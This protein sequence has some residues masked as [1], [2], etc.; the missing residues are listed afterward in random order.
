MATT[1]FT[2]L[3]I[4]DG[5]N[6]QDIFRMCELE[7]PTEIW[8]DLDRKYYDRMAFIDGSTKSILPNM[9]YSIG[10]PV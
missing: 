10:F 1:F 2:T 6:R 3:S 4:N 8:T 7:K 5:I 9:V